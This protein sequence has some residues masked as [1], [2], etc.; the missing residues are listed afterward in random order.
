MKSSRR[1]K[2]RKSR[3]KAIENATKL[4][5]KTQGVF[6]G[7]SIEKTVADRKVTQTDLISWPAS[8]IV[9]FGGKS[10][11]ILIEYSSKTTDADLDLI[12]AFFSKLV[13]G[14]VFTIVKGTTRWSDG[15]NKPEEKL[16]GDYRFLS[17]KNNTCIIA[18]RVSDFDKEMSK[19]SLIGTG[20]TRPIQFSK[21]GK[22]SSAKKTNRITNYLQDDSFHKLKIKNGDSISIEGT[23]LNDG[24][25]TV[26]DMKTINDKESIKIAPAVKDEDLIGTEVLIKVIKKN[27]NEDIN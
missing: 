7:L 3:T 12:S 24:I 19:K 22:M 16:F 14:E 10:N 2:S 27:Q 9:G 20:F 11:S 25:Y 15:V 17:Y 23:T 5:V 13:P 21:T 1:S 4:I 6:L 8:V 18:E 26:L